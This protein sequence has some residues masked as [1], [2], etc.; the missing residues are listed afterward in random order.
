MGLVRA[1]ASRNPGLAV[2]IFSSA[3]MA[4]G[5]LGPVLSIGVASTFGFERL[6]WVAAPV[7][8]VAVLLA[9]FGPTPTR[10]PAQ[11]P[12][13]SPISLIRG[14]IAWLFVVALLGS[15]VALTFTS[16]MPVWLVT[17][18]GLTDTSPVIGLTLAT[19]SL[20]AACGGILGG[21]LARSVDPKRLVVGS[22]ALSVVA[23]ES[24]LLTTPGSA[25]YTV[26]VAA[27]GALL[28]VHG[29]LVI[30][31]AQEL[32]P[33]A[34][35]AVAGLLLGTTWGVAGLV[36]AGFG[37]AQSLLGVEGT[38]TIVSLLVLPA[39]HLAALTLRNVAEPNTAG[40]CEDSCSHELR[41]CEEVPAAA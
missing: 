10:R 17:E 37:A 11:R 1:T 18:R 3:G 19:F 28:G 38:L 16:A 13:I 14:P 36:Y 20:A 29:P 4:G 24:A 41:C 40:R 5:A 32:S 2:A 15:V 30:A 31:R 25:P 23:L 9:K 27:A 33:G 7:L 34:E 35:S 6:A 21:V 8:F 12:R 22:L 39:A 26:A